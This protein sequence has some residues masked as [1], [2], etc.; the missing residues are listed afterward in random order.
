M[1]KIRHLMRSSVS[2]RSSALYLGTAAVLLGAMPAQAQ[3]YDAEGKK[4]E[5]ITVTGRRV[6]EA[7]EAIGT[8]K[9]TNTVAITREAL[10]SAP[11]GISGLKMLETCPA[12]TSRPT[13]RWAFMNLATASRPAPSTWTRSV[14]WWM[15][16]PT[17]RSDAFGG[18]PVFRYV[19]NENLGWFRPRRAR[20]MSACRAIPRSGPMVEYN[21][22]APQED[23]GLFISQ[24][25][26]DFDDEAHLCEGLDR[27]GRPFKA[28]VSRT[29]LASAICGAARA[30][31]TAN[32]GKARSTPTLAAAAGRASSSCLTTS[33]TNDSPTLRRSHYN[34]TGGAVDAD[35]KCGRFFGYTGTLYD[36]PETTPGVALFE[37]RLYTTTGWRSTPQ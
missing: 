33:T 37:Q 10:L 15:A 12:S 36:Y 2:R 32:T 7:D 25:F 3:T 26:G 24:S 11:S 27:A 31:R 16:F 18:S 8:G 34:C 13:A 23:P 20:V 14:S 35:G 5:E 29:K 4:A 19:D 6:S 30:R 21:S 1:I 22:I 28:Y 9:V 17:G